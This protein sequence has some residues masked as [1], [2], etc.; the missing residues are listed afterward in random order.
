MGTFTR[1][2][3][4][5]EI[6][7]KLA[8]LQKL[9]QDKRYGGICLTLA[10]DF[11][12]I[13]GGLADN[14]IAHSGEVGS[15]TLV[16]LPDGRKFVVAAHSE[17][18]RLMDQALGR[19]GYE[20]IETKWFAAAPDLSRRLNLKGPLASD[21]PLKDCVVVDLALLRRPLTATEVEKYKVAGLRCVE[22]VAEVTR[23]VRPGMTEREIE[24]MSAHALMQRGLRPTV[25]LIGSDERIYRYRHCLPSDKPVEKYAMVN[26]CARRWGLVVSAT[27]F[28]HFGPLAKELRERLRAAAIVNANYFAALRPGV[29]AADIF[30]RAKKWYADQGFPGEWEFHHQGGGTGYREREYVVHPGS[31]EVVLDHEAFAFN[32][33]VQ[34][35][36]VEDTV[37]VM[38]DR[39]E[40]ITT[41][42][43]WPAMN[44]LVNGKTYA[45]PDI[46][47]HGAAQ[48]A[49]PD[50]LPSGKPD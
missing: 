7:E 11:S 45:C 5:G 20:P 12:W 29:R 16:I 2:G 26:V 50:P 23:Q 30:E 34:G 35:A 22:A 49:W 13:T 10:A 3:L 25:L 36:K 43:D 15:A 4:A 37:I 14:Q 48:T 42:A 1:D 18:P 19:L 32:P 39:V 8:R 33:T 28:V 17:V 47:I 38:G 24:T 44:V 21:I 6:S 40:N 41:L 46:L 9:I 31:E 27:R